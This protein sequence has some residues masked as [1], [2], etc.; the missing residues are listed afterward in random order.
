MVK[1]GIGSQRL[2]IHKGKSKIMWKNCEYM[3]HRAT[4]VEAGQKNR[5][6]TCK[7][8]REYVKLPAVNVEAG[9]IL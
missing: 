9:H 8:N 1:G 4:N 3:K 6:Y 7:K 2:L 5:E